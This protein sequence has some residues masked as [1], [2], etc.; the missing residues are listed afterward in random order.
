MALNLFEL[1]AKIKLDK[2]DFES[3]LKST[4]GMMAKFS[5]GFANTIK[6][7]G[8]VA[9]TAA[10]AGVAAFG[11]LAKSA[12]FAAGELEQGLGGAEAVFGEW[13]ENIKA[14]ANTA[15]TSM[16]LSATDFLATANKMGSLLRGVGYS[17][18]D[19]SKLA[20]EAMQRASDVASIMGISI[21]AAMESITGAMKGNFTMMDNLGVAINDTT[22]KAYAA[23]K[24]MKKAAIDNLSTQE[25]VG[26]ALELF[27]EKT[28]YAAGNY[29]KEND[30][31]AGSITTLKAAWDNFLSGAGG[32]NAPTV[33]SD[34]ISNTVD[35]VL[36]NLDEIIPRLTA[37]LGTM[38]TTLSEK[39]P[40]IM[41]KLMPG[42]QSGAE[43]LIGLL[44]GML[45]TLIETAV[46]LL[47]AIVTGLTNVIVK[48]GEKAPE[49]LAGL[50]SGLKDAG[51]QLGEI[52]FGKDGE[53]IKWPTWSDVDKYAVAA[54]ETIQSGVDSLGG[55]V[56]GANEDGTV[57]WPTWEKIG[58][59]VREAWDVIVAEA[60]ALTGFVLGDMDGT[61]TKLD[62]LKSKWT[63]LKS[64]VQNNTVD[65]IAGLTGGN[66]E[67]IANVVDGIV[68]IFG[69][70]ISI[71]ATIYQNW[72]GI[73]GYFTTAWDTI[74]AGANV[75]WEAVSKW[76]VSQYD[77]IT[78]AWNSAT[79]WLKNAWNSV[80]T[81]ITEAWNA[82]N[83]W[84]D[85]NT[86]EWIKSIW[87][88]VKDTLV[89]VWNDITGAISGAIEKVKEF[90]GLNSQSGPSLVD[91]A[92]NEV[93]DQFGAFNGMTD[94]QMAK[95]GVYRPGSNAKGLNYVPYDNYVSR[96]HRG[97][98]VLN[99]SRAE[100]YREGGT[101]DLTGLT[102]AITAAVRAGMQ[103]V[104]YN[105]ALDGEKVAH[106][107]TD[108]QMND[109]MAWR[110]AVT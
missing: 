62:G 76:T 61:G 7:A 40:E 10:A 47:P 36:K 96:L 87:A 103:G 35:I 29:A 107:T 65:F 3:G 90:L 33:L 19:A 80:T 45:P 71:P 5:K 15:A 60:G 99:R 73:T 4:E 24:G 109:Q 77:K 50:W 14:A 108:R 100:E 42:L 79:E 101:G 106:N 38:M 88:G 52:L 37:G 9:G 89:G 13:A 6:V 53:K 55:I 78:S 17:Q 26:L 68:E 94:E 98:M 39:L 34:S 110:F 18:M 83:Q 74:S 72:D 12:L 67:D 92:G 2:K 48:V 31:L 69:N 51:S 102:A 56:F 32:E 41:Q 43:A 8:A 75:A 64:T 25:K 84:L 85:Q 70:I 44:A 63:E 11:K 59:K 66:K 95:W 54:W 23:Q 82:V 27:M 16:G 28:A 91:S 86:P 20:V 58:G 93:L 30:T 104:Q 81:P 22:I 1:S 97:E 105:F 46:G 49:I 57:K 21:D